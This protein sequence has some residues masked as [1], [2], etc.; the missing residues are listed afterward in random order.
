MAE[1]ITRRDDAS[2]SPEMSDATQAAAMARLAA[3]YRQENR[4]PLSEAERK[5]REGYVALPMTDE[6]RAMLANDTPGSRYSYVAVC[7][8]VAWV[9][10]LG[11]LIWLHQLLVNQTL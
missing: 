3:E 4:P 11:I 7:L 6:I 9:L 2:G 5:E 10:C 8:G 1:G